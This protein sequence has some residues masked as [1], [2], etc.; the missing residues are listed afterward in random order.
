MNQVL[1]LIL[2]KLIVQK[3]FILKIYLYFSKHLKA[4]LMNLGPKIMEVRFQITAAKAALIAGIVCVPGAILGSIFG[5]VAIL[6][7]KLSGRGKS[8]ILQNNYYLIIN[9]I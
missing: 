3:L 6:V 1:F 7:F 2:Y 5:G 9:K 8:L 4:G